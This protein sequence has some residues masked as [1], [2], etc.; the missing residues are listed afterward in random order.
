MATLLDALIGGGDRLQLHVRIK[1]AASWHSA[2]CARW[3]RI[4]SRWHAAARHGSVSKGSGMEKLMRKVTG[5]RSVRGLVK[6]GPAC[7]S[8]CFRRC[9]SSRSISSLT[10]NRAHGRVQRPGLREVVQPAQELHQTPPTDGSI[11]GTPETYVRIDCRS[12]GRDNSGFTWFPTFC[13]RTASSRARKLSR[14]TLQH[15]RLGPPARPGLGGLHAG[16]LRCS[17]R[18]SRNDT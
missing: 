9:S 10:S 8:F 1:G 2:G 7:S 13:N 5:D 15:L 12:R 11:A 17:G 16:P 6:P 18:L 14:T 4:C 3:R